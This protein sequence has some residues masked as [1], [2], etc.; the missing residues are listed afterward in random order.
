MLNTS[1]NCQLGKVGRSA[2]ASTMA[3]GIRM[4]YRTGIELC[5]HDK[6]YLMVFDPV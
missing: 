6:Q 4:H 3:C 2:S 5:V 1:V